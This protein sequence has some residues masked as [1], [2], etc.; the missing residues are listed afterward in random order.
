MVSWN[1][2]FYGFSLLRTYL[3][4]SIYLSKLTQ[5]Y[6]KL[7]MTKLYSSFHLSCL[8]LNLQKLGSISHLLWL[9]I[10]GKIFNI[11]K[12]RPLKTYKKGAATSQIFMFADSIRLYAFKKKIL[13]RHNWTLSKMKTKKQITLRTIIY[14]TLQDNC[15]RLNEWKYIPL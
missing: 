11:W 12:E 1:Y 3:S 13:I 5:N 2:I 9:A 8:A 7:K 15:L 14:P 4:S 6:Y 10:P